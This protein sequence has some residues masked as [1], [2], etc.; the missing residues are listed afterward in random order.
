MVSHLF[1]KPIFKEP[2]MLRNY[3]KIALRNILRHKAY[4]AI[5]ISG[6]AI[7]MASSI[8]ILLWVQNELSFDKFHTNADQIYRITADASGFKAAVNPAG[9]PAG[10]QAVMPVIKNTVRLSHISSALFDAGGDRK[11]EEKK[12][13]YADSTFLEI[14]SF[15]LL[16]GDRKTALLRHDGVLLTAAMAKKYFGDHEALGQTLKKDDGKYVT[17]TGVLADI[18]SNSHLQFDFILPLVAQRNN[19]YSSF[20]FYSYVLLDNNF[21]PTPSAM[22]RINQQ[23]N[24]VFKQHVKEDVIK[25]EFQLQPLTAIH[26]D[27]PLQVDLPGHGNRQYVNIFFIVAIFI[28]IVACINFMNL[29][30]AR[31]ARRA[32]EV[33]LRKVVGAV[34]GQIVRQFLGEALLISFFALVL[35][36][37]LVGLCLPL[38]NQLANKDLSLRLWDGKLLLTLLSISIL[39]GLVA[40]SYPAL[41]LSGFQPVK[42]LKGNLRTLG[43]NLLFRNGLVITQ[44]VVSIVLL[45]G[46]IVVYNQLEF[47]RSRNMGFEK[48]NLL[49]IPMKG[50]IWSKQKTLRTQLEQNPLTSSY[51]ILSELP[52]DIM[53]GDADVQWE[54][55]DPRSQIIIP[56]LAVSESFIDVFHMK[57]LRGR[58]FSPAFKADSNNYIINET[59]VRTMGFTMNNAVGKHLG[60][61]DLKGTVIGVV[62][63]FN[64]KP[65][66]Q[67]IEPLILHINSWGGTVV[68]RAGSGTTEATIH[69]LEKI[70]KDLNPA[71][72][73]SYNFLDQDLANLYKGEEQMG[74]IFKLFAF[75]A[76]F[77]SGLGLYGLSAFM[78]QQRTKEIGV[79]KVLGASIFNIVYLLS[80]GFT[81]LILIAIVISVPL[82]FFAIHRWLESFAYHIEVG[83]TVFFLA[84]MAAL[85]LAWLTVSFE[86][87]K[88]AIINP[89]SSLRS[90]E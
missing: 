15:P 1:K 42:V 26:L 44:F 69:A 49:Y 9:M 33:G 22:A 11:F 50:E 46:T 52:I 60:W 43:G 89:A 58:D 80:T 79:R 56:S 90:A 88:A 6:L 35:A 41:F 36:I 67:V 68:V 20:N 72:P 38:F 87:I 32:K 3:F 31:S 19:V 12:I 65:I 59:A 64:F 53:S 83:W 86:T 16:K 13:F 45:A 76:I 77:I 30:T 8:L 18:P 73:F 27:P 17:V 5:N 62:K 10:L 28:L 55:K 57:I 54:G 51:T 61:G 71:Y 48:E 78:A 39:T 24:Q 75:L 4:S 74:N 2:L 21:V 70:T 7:G 84:S 63:D 85:I 37:A 23:M 81:R 14:F 40:G 34:R 82:S 29:A 66:H 25:A 47:I